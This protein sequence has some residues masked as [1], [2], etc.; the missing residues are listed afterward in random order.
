[1]S[2]LSKV[3][4]AAAIFAFAALAVAASSKNLNVSLKATQS[5]EDTGKSTAGSFFLLDDVDAGTDASLRTVEKDVRGYSRLVM[6]V[7]LTDADTDCDSVEVT[8]SGSLDGGVT[9]GNVTSRAVEDGVGTVTDYYDTIVRAQVIDGVVLV[10]DIWGYW[11]FKCV[12]STTGACG[13]DT[14]D[15]QW[16]LA[17]DK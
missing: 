15:V 11:Y 12:Y 6:Y 8:C 4:A 14:L 9:Y 17:A 7:D 13:S 16:A 3:V 2:R 5:D 1:M 10:Y